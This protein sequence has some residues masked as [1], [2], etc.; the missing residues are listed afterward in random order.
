MVAITTHPV[1]FLGVYVFLTSITF[2]FLLLFYLLLSTLVEKNNIDNVFLEQ[3]WY[4]SNIMSNCCP[5]LYLKTQVSSFSML[6]WLHAARSKDASGLN[7]RLYGHVVDPIVMALQFLF[8]YCL[9]QQFSPTIRNNLSIHVSE[10][11]CGCHSICK[12]RFTFSSSFA[13][14]WGSQPKSHYG[15]MMRYTLT[16][17]D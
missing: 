16:Y 12:K 1:T 6:H 4:Y 15:E 11:L 8:T 14:S 9:S 2:I 10:R 5:V 7:R 13:S 3:V 17:G